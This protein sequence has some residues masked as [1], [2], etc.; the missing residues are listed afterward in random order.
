MATSPNPSAGSDIGP[1][2]D[3]GSSSARKV[4]PDNVD[5]VAEAPEETT[6]AADETGVSREHPLLEANGAT[7]Q[8]A[9]KAGVDIDEKKEVSIPTQP[10]A[11]GTPPPEQSGPPDEGS[12]APGTVGYW[13]QIDCSKSHQE[14]ESALYECMKSKYGRELV[15]D[16]DDAQ[17]L[18]SYFTRNGLAED[19]KIDDAVVET[20]IVSRERLRTGVFESQ[21]EEA[22][23]RMAY[24]RIAKAAQP[25][26]VAS[27]RDSTA[28]ASRMSLKWDWAK[29]RPYLAP[30]SRPV[31][32]IAC[33]RYRN[34]A[35]LVLFA[36]VVVQSYWTATSSVLTKTDALITEI[37]HAPT[38]QE[39]I[40][41]E[42]ALR[43]TKTGADP[44][45]S[46]SSATPA[47]AVVAAAKTDKTELT[48]DELVSKIGEME[49]NY[50]MLGKFMWPFR[51]LQFDREKAD[52]KDAAKDQS[53]NG[54]PTPTASPEAA[55]EKPGKDPHDTLFLPSKFQTE[56]ASIRAVA[57][58]VIDVMQKWLL[59][60]LYGA[61]G[62]MVFVVRTLSMQ[63]RDRLFR[64]EG[65]VSLVLRVF[66]GM[67]SGLAIG[68]F[69]NQNPQGAT[70]V[71]ALT[72]TT[73]SPFALAF[74]AGYGVE[75]FFALLDKIVSTFTNKT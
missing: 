39:Y 26:T 18:L 22:K 59:P 67:I 7:E 34:F 54:T 15:T 53:T 75:L 24:G 41:R 17:L 42:T 30:E 49:A 69:W 58:Q 8:I 61:L 74:V 62:A 12:A 63:A 68:W 60:L 71:G 46:A 13:P 73:L 2:P 44:A 72:A 52:K 43:P 65:L 56:S 37:N 19:R 57:V 5:P 40:D 36:L 45:K 48:K 16:M 6:D 1:V 27:L 29:N 9:F 64:R 20:L 32:E 31:P 4:Q 50:S 55:N 51:W 28:T 10:A 3:G 35:F 25:V 23:F 38:K 33:L 21:A 47:P 14:V 11:G 70:S 66:L